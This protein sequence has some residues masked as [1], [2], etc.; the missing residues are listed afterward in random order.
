MDARIRRLQAG[1]TPQVL[2]VVET[3]FKEYGLWK[4]HCCGL[5]DL[6]K[7]PL[8][9]DGGEFLVLEADGKI[10]GCGGL[11]PRGRGVGEI[12]RMFLRPEARGRGFGRAILEKLV[13]AARKRGMRRLV[14]ETSDRFQDAIT[15]YLRCGFQAGVLDE[16]CCNVVMFRTISSPS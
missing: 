13:S 16:G 15:L 6:R 3:V 12:R 2:R 14:L 10:L 1:D 4:E 7:A 5:D 9:Y 11:M 8:S